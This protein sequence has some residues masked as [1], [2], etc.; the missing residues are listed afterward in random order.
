M[1]L[2]VIISQY[3]HISS[4]Y[5]IPLKLIYVNYISIKKKTIMERNPNKSRCLPSI[6]LQLYSGLSGKWVPQEPL[7]II[8]K[9]LK[10]QTI[11]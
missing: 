8:S 3:V 6:N 1:R 10:M 9:I 4:H 7:M 5:I 11:P 2:T